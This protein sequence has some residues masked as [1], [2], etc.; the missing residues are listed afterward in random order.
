VGTNALAAA[1]YLADAQA[2]AAELVA[3]ALG[4]RLSP[5]EDSDA[6]ARVLGRELIPLY[7]HYIDD[8]TT[9]LMAADRPDLARSFEQWR[10]RLLA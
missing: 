4:W 5:P 7:L 9:R 2:P 8:H 1:H 6:A 10:G 3:A